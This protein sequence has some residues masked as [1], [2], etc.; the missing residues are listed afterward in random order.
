MKVLYIEDDIIDQMAVRRI[1]EKCS[2][3]LQFVNSIKE[4]NDILQ[5]EKFDLIITDF[6]LG[7]GTAE[8]ILT[9]V[10]NQKIV[11]ITQKPLDSFHANGNILYSITKPLNESIFEIA[12]KVQP[13]DFT[14]FNS[15]TEGDINFQIELLDTALQVLP[16]ALEKVNEAIESL[17]FERLK[18][19]A[20]KMK[21][22]ARVIGIPILETLQTI[23]ELALTGEL[24][25]LSPLIKELNQKARSGID[26]VKIEREK[27]Q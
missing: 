1:T 24:A 9:M 19:E 10:T 13:L 22:G 27:L 8:E 23:E 21:S 16:S 17:N 2:Y 7:D 25:K 12:N 6:Y 14:Y 4:A 26:L 18:F 11:L 3:E 5:A 20:H 15:L